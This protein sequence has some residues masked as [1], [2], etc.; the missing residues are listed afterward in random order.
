MTS[1]VT[2]AWTAAL[3]MVSAGVQGKVQ[4]HELLRR[5]YPLHLSH[6]FGMLPYF[7]LIDINVQFSRKQLRLAIFDTSKHTER[8]MNLL[9]RAA[10]V[11][12]L[13]QG[14][15]YEF[16]AYTGMYPRRWKWDVWSSL[17]TPLSAVA[18]PADIS[19]VW[20]VTAGEKVDL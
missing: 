6:N 19:S 1:T 16:C 2:Q 7:C 15:N 12:N 10:Q 20:A 4:L 18:V 5:S 11:L 8:R 14:R 13:R 17:K 3:T 9:F